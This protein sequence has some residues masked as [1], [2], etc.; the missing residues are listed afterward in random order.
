MSTKGEIENFDFSNYEP[1]KSET[2]SMTS[3]HLRVMI[4]E[5][6]FL[7]FL[8]QASAENVRVSFDPVSVEEVRQT[9]ELN[10]SVRLGFVPPAVSTR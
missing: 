1:G 8:V 3:A 4:Q 9:R 5:P 10:R 7:K 2:P 6:V